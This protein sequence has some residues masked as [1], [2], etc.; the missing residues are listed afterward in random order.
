MATG[1]LQVIHLHVYALLDP[2]VAISF[3]TPYISVYFGVS[4]EILV[5]PFSVST[6]IN[7]SII[8]RRVYKNCLIIISQK[9]TSVDLMEL[10]RTDFDIIISMYWIH[11][12]YSLVDHRNRTVQFYFLN[13]QV[14]G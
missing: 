9:I 2:K 1:M 7:T 6:L 10:A 14:L 4:L 13:D 11:Y 12:F 3:V 5:E 8:A